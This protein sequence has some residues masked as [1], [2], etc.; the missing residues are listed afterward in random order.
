MRSKIS[1][2]MVLLLIFS[3]ATVFAAGQAEA[4]GEPARLA[5]ATGGTAGVY[6][7][8][9]G[10][11]ANIISEKV[12]GVTANAES[13]GASVVNVNLL[14]TGE[15]DFAMIQND[16]AYYAF[17]GEEMFSD[18]PAL[19]NLRGVASIYPEVIQIV[20]N[21]NAGIDS[22]ND[23]RGK[24]VAVGAPGSGTEAN[25]RQ[26]LTAHGI[27]YDDIRA[28]FLSFAE[29]ADALRDGNVDAAFVTAGLPTAAVTDVST[30]HNVKILSIDDSVA[31]AI[32]ADYPFY[33]QVTIP[34]GTYSRQDSDVSTV[35]VMAMLS[36]RAGL[37]EDLVYRVTKA[38]F[39]N[40]DMFAAAHARGGNLSLETATGGMPLD[41]HPG[42]A[43]YFREVGR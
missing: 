6:Y 16:I 15:V 17:N 38:L 32:I 24:R 1:M 14:N 43:R 29:A 18:N 12:A 42:A 41:L 20:V 8:L 23:L 19:A 2:L 36:V 22:M 37:S 30:T 25:A 9:G 26:I 21:A 28:D 7:P 11:F 10:A 5:V 13:T 3:V 35:A 34:A 31:R 39:E 4:P 33:D 40:L 27:S